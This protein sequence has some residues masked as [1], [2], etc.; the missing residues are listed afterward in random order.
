[1]TFPPGD[2][3]SFDPYLPPLTAR[4]RSR[5]AASFDRTIVELLSSTR[6]LAEGSTMVH[7]LLA[8]QNPPRDEAFTLKQATEI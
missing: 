4:I 1:M 3:T 2:S 5:D 7:H 6:K 8:T